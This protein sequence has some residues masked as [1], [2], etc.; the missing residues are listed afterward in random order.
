MPLADVEEI[1]CQVDAESYGNRVWPDKP[2]YGAGGCLYRIRWN[3][4]QRPP[5]WKRIFQQYSVYRR[6]IR[7]LQEANR[8][9]QQKYDEARRLAIELETSNRELTDSKQQLEN[10]MAELKTSEGRYRLLAES[11]TDT[12]WTMSLDPLRFTYVSPSVL[13]MRGYSVEEATAMTLEQTLTPESLKLV[14]TLLAERLG[15]EIEGNPDANESTTVELQQ[16]CK[17]GST[18]WAEVIASFIRDE[19]G[20]PMGMLGVSR[21]ISE[22]KRAEQLYKAKIAAEASNAAKSKFLSNMSHEFRT[23]LNHIIGFTELLMGKSFGSLNPV[24]EEYLSDVHESSL[25]LLSLVNDVLDVS[26]IEAGKLELKPS[27]IDLKTLLEQSLTIITDTA[28]TRN[29]DLKTTIEQIPSTIGA[30]Q[31]RLKQILYNLLS[32]AAKF[33]PDGGSVRLSA[34]MTSGKGSPVAAESMRNEV[35]ISVADNGIGIRKEDLARIFEPF[36]QLE[37][38]LSRKYPGTG[39]GLS[40]ARNLVEMHGGRIWV[41]SDGPGKGSTFRFTLPI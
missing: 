32:N 18:A 22:R 37:N 15:R 31:L 12:I 21:D 19:K 13:R 23:P 9:I 17:D 27:E 36:S 1:E 30:D 2:V 40:L 26:K 28:R 4:K 34:R 33:T 10:Y 25:H 29:I 8:L 5:L 38:S 20:V 7:E 3:S 16:L 24:Q 39:L 35:E 14:S 6:A 11:V 41:E